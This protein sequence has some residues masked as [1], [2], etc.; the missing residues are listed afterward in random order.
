MYVALAR[1]LD[2]GLIITRRAIVALVRVV[3]SSDGP[4]QT[5]SEEEH[6]G[7]LEDIGTKIVNRLTGREAY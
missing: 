5:F 4:L 1:L 7:F 2:S 6:P 3:S